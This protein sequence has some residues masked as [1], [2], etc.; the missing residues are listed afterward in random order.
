M[1]SSSAVSNHMD[2]NPPGSSVLGISQARTLECVAISFSRGSSQ[3]GTEPASPALIGRQFFTTETP[4]KP[5]SHY[6]YSQKDCLFFI[7]SLQ[8]YFLSRP[9]NF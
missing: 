7:S 4:G 9:D 5:I 1:L 3:P 8:N 2:C 6:S